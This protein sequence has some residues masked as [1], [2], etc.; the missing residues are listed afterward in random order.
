MYRRKYFSQEC[1]IEIQQVFNL[2][3]KVVPI[4]PFFLASCDFSLWDEVLCL[5][6]ILKPCTLQQFNMSQ[7][8]IKNKYE[9]VCFSVLLNTIK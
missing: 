4:F 2:E 7:N 9:F 1:F 3:N 8:D 5:A 6:A